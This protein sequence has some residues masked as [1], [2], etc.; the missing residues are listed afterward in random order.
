MDTY[1]FDFEAT[2]RLKW[3]SLYG[4]VIVAGTDYWDAFLT[5]F[6]MVYGMRGVEMVTRL[7]LVV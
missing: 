5:A 3:P 6:A 1:W 4:R 2:D 7:D